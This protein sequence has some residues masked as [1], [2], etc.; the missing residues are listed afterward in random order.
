M[1]KGGIT[2]LLLVQNKLLGK[3]DF[4]E[5]TLLSGRASHDVNVKSD[6]FEEEKQLGYKKGYQE[7]T[8]QVQLEWAD[9]LAFLNN[10]SEVLSQ[11]IKDV[12]KLIQEKSVEIAIA[13]SR[14][15][16]RR[17]LSLDSGQIVSAVKQAIEL[18][19]KDGEKINLHI[20]PNDMQHVSQ[21]FS[22]EDSSSKY[23]FIQDPSIEVGG[24]KALTDYS[25]VDLT[26]D[27]QIASIA[28]QIFGDQR[29]AAR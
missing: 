5:N 21:I 28:A 7:A 9:K 4:Q 23:N 15:I 18:I 14:Q 17:E 27:K 2:K 13:I 20:N 16:I 6:A 1:S 11:P 29:N 25:L 8:S 26:I 24:C 19:P 12:D 10:I 3:T 22:E